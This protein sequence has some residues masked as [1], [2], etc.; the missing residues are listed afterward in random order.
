VSTRRNQMSARTTARLACGGEHMQDTSGFEAG[1]REL[2]R[3]AAE[4]KGAPVAA[5]PAQSTR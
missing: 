4:A 2:G 5:P 3:G 1:A